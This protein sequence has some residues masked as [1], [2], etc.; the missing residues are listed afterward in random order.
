MPLQGQNEKLAPPLIEVTFPVTGLT[1][2]R[3]MQMRPTRKTAVWTGPFR[4]ACVTVLFPAL[5]GSGTALHAAPAAMPVPIQEDLKAELEKRQAA[6][7]DTDAAGLFELAMWAEANG[8]KTDSK[9]ILRKVIKVD[10]DHAEARKILGYVQHEGN[11][12]TERERDR[13]IAKAEEAA[14]EA[15]G[16]KKWEGEWYP[17]EDVEKFQKGLVKI[18]QN[19]EVLWVT[20]R[21]KERIEKGLVLYKGQWI[22]QEEKSNID[23]GLY[24]VGENWVTEAEANQAHA[25]LE[26]PWE[27]DGDYLTMM[28]TCDLQFGNKAS[29]HARKSIEQA[30]KILG[31]PLAKPQDF[32]KIGVMMVRTVDDYNAIGNSAQD[33]HDAVMSSTYPCFSFQN[34]ETSQY[35]GVVNFTE[36]PGAQQSQNEQ[37][38]AYLVRHAAAEAAIRSLT[39]KEEIPRWFITGV[40]TYCERYWDPFYPDGVKAL[41]TWS[42]TNLNNKGGLL[43]LKSFFEPFTITEQTLLQ[44]GLLI[45]YLLHGD[46]P[47][48][49]KEQLEKVREMIASK[50]QKGL[51]KEFLRFEALLGKE[52]QESFEAYA[53]KVLKGA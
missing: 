12:V 48:E 17:A 21:D 37:Y 23:K 27:I 46:P 32:P 25:T 42:A 41:A 44:S 49:V 29:D 11:W 28:T 18:E 14:K 4:A 35:F 38:T 39:L 16:L 52:G 51:A 36:L 13:L 53:D 20:K 50:D 15:Q 40:A 26:N 10:K 2:V 7:A 30:Y 19:G 47:K 22:S 8:L 1:E 45:S 6:V 5:L 34:P 3:K 24:K 43:N 31:V 33:D 9:R